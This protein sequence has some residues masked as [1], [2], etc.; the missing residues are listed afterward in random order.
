M[1][2]STRDDIGF[3]VVYDV[4]S[5]IQQVILKDHPGMFL[6][7]TIVRI[8]TVLHIAIVLLHICQTFLY[9]FSFFFFF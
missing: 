3:I 8:T 5:V 4:I 7:S 2:S 1:N 6:L 9:V